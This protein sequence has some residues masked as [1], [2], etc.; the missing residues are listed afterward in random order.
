MWRWGLIVVVLAGCIDPIDLDVGG[1][2][3]RVVVEGTLVSGPGPHYVIL[4][5]AATFTQGIDALRERIEGAEVRILD[6]AGG[7]FDLV[8]VSPGRYETPAGS[9]DGQA[10]RSYKLAIQTPDGERFE[11]A[12]ELMREALP[13]DSLWAELEP[14]TGLVNNNPVQRHRVTWRVNAAAP[15]G[16]SHYYRW[17]WRGVYDAPTADDRICYHQIVGRDLISIGSNQRVVGS[18]LP[19]QDAGRVVLEAPIPPLGS[20]NFAV[21][22]GFGGMKLEV[23]QQ[24]LSPGAYQYWSQV[25]V[26]GEDV[27]SL[28]DPPPYDVV[29]N[30]RSVSDPTVA[31]LGYFTVAGASRRELC[32]RRSDLPGFPLLG[33]VRVPCGVFGTTPPP[34]WTAVCG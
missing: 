17:V 13:I 26:L 25:R 7:E 21:M 22:F 8:E 32:V 18:V 14:F 19:R 16:S 4:S 6:D 27:G 10:G 1:A 3:R 24:V 29:G 23:E 33:Q 28:F 34:S 15:P 2:E 20:G 5:R 31:A 30:V 11:S 12:Y 9:L